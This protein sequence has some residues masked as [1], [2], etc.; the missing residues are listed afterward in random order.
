MAGVRIVFMGTPDLAAT[1]LKRLAGDPR[2]HIVGA[3]SQ[4]DRPKGRRLR[5]QPTPVR[6]AAEA[7]GIPVHQPAKARDPAFLE[8]LRALKTDLI[9]VAAYGQLLPQQLLDIPAHGSLNVHT[10]LLPRYRG[11]APIQWAILNGDAE[12]GVTIMKMTAELD[13]GDILSQRR[14][15]IDADDNAQT[16]HDRL[17]V[18]GAELLAETIPPHVAGKIKPVPQPSE[19]IVY[20]RKIAKTD[21]QLDWTR[22]GTELWNQVRGLA[23]WPGAFTQLPSEIKPLLLKVWDAKPEEGAGQPGVI[24][25]ADASGIVVA[26]GLGALRILDLQLEGKRRMTA[27]A[28]LAGHRLKAGD[29][30]G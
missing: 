19:G 23:P 20:A 15:S 30:F 10:S 4:P 3:V 22:P 28:F 6:L 16:L 9:A 18:L 12:T 11:A 17:A 27:E 5:V 8:K 13:A 21:G 24:L 29:R 2:F 14:T 7:A 25:S 26:T 1:C